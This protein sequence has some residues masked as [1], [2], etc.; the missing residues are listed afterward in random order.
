MRKQLRLSS[1]IGTYYEHLKGAPKPIRSSLFYFEAAVEL[2]P[3]YHL[4]ISWL[5]DQEQLFIGAGRSQECG[6]LRLLRGAD[7]QQGEVG[8]FV[9]L[10]HFRVAAV[11]V[12]F[13]L[14]FVVRLESKQPLLSA[15]QFSGHNMVAGHNQT[16]SDEKAGGMGIWLD[17]ADK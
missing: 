11:D 6:L 3:S 5:S 8:F 14:E 7:S 15:A 17:G 4:L 12:S 1:P 9:N 13:D 2:A 16:I 10:Y